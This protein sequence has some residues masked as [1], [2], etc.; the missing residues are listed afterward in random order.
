MLGRFPVLPTISVKQWVLALSSCQHRPNLFT[1]P[2]RNMKSH[3]D[4]FKTLFS[5]LRSS[6]PSI[7]LNT[8]G[9]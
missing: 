6:S 9:F 1:Q 5:Q 7:F 4:L 2:H 3:C 8:M